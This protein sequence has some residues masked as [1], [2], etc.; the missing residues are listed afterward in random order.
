MSAILHPHQ[1]RLVER[2]DEA[3][4]DDCRRLVVQMATGGGKTIVAAALA[5][6]ILEAGRRLIFT[7]PAL[8]LIDR[9]KVLRRRHP[10]PRR[11]PSKPRADELRAPDPDRKCADVAAADDSAG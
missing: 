7:V 11:H 10:R 2:I 4:D 6:G 8:S 5:R 1:V 9:R 3:L